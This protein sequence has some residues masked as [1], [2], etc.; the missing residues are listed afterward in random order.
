MTSNFMFSYSVKVKR[1]SDAHEKVAQAVRAK[2]ARISNIDWTKLDEVETTIK[3]LMNISG[4]NLEARRKC[5]Q[6]IVN[7]ELAFILD[8]VHLDYLPRIHVALS[9]DGLGDAILF[10]VK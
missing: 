9:V 10:E 3:G 6:R 5:A 4:D 2:I 1:E 7:K 8:D